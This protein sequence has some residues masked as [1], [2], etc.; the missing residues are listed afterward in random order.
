MKTLFVLTVCFSAAF[1]LSFNRQLLRVLAEL[2]ERSITDANPSPTPPPPTSTPS[3]QT[4]TPPP[5]TTSPLPS[6]S[7]GSDFHGEHYELKPIT[8]IEFKDTLKGWENVS[9]RFINHINELKPM[10]LQ[11]LTK[12]ESWE[13]VL[14]KFDETFRHGGYLYGKVLTEALDV[15]HRL[16]ENATGFG[17]SGRC[18]RMITLAP[19]W[20]PVKDPLAG[21]KKLEAIVSDLGCFA[22]EVQDTI[23]TFRSVCVEGEDFGVDKALGMIG[24]VMQV[25]YRFKRDGERFGEA[26]EI[27][28]AKAH[29]AFKNKMAGNLAKRLLEKLISKL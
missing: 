4:S 6:P 24:K 26:G 29:K 1:G 14:K 16:F 8:V 3:P 15:G 18:K 27:I 2:R 9:N 25:L 28:E 17:E 7:P 12:P 13:N 22:G 20:D 11:T 23:S 19:T 5:P 10:A 21:E